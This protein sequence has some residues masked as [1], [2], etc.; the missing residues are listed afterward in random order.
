V[1]SPA[2][3]HRPD[4]STSARGIDASFSVSALFSGCHYL[5]ARRHALESD[6]LAEAP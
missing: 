4:S 1:L 5:E 3:S 2:T 6:L